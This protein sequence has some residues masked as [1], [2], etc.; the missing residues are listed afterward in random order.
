MGPAS[1]VDFHL[2][3]MGVKQRLLSRGGACNIASDPKE[4]K[5]HRDLIIFDR[6]LPFPSPPLY[7]GPQEPA[8]KWNAPKKEGGTNC[9][10]Y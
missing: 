9:S 6:Q 8:K 10:K 4:R 7:L 1:N 5:G 2:G 3:T